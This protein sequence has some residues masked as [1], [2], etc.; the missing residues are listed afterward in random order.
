MLELSKNL[1]SS[2]ISIKD[3][4]SKK[5]LQLLGY[6][7]QNLGE[8]QPYYQTFITAWQQYNDYV[9]NGF[10]EQKKKLLL[11]DVATLREIKASLRY[12]KNLKMQDQII[13][14]IFTNE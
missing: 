10:F 9:I 5:L 6:Q 11:N 12:Q 1:D 4:N 3:G 2:L 13:C 7:Y 8:I 14:P